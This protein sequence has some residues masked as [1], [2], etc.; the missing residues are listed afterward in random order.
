MQP[1]V[2]SFVSSYMKKLEKYYT[3]LEIKAMKKHQ[4]KQLTTHNTMMTLSNLINLKLLE[5]QSPPHEKIKLISQRGYTIYSGCQRESC[6]SAN[7][8]EV[9]EVAVAMLNEG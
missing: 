2:F 3:Y 8:T 5:P 4:F 9:G 7:G 6:N 1:N